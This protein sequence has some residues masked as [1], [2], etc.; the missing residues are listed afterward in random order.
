MPSRVL[1]GRGHGKSDPRLLARLKQQALAL[2]LGVQ[3]AAETAVGWVRLK[4]LRQG[5]NDR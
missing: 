4:V 2:R 5:G 1:S 3:D